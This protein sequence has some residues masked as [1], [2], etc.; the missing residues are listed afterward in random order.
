MDGRP[1]ILAIETA[2]PC[3]SVALCRGGLSD[4]ALVAEIGGRPDKT[5]SRRLLVQ[6]KFLL[7]QSELSWTD[8]DGVAVSLGPG[9]FT[10]L[11]IGMA[12][13]RGI[14]MAAG[15]PLLGVPT[16][17]GIALANGQC[18]GPLHVIL[19][20]RKRQ[21]FA[22]SYQAHGQGMPV[23]QGEVLAIAPD[24]LAARLHA[25]ATLVGDGV[26]LYA[27]VFSAIH[28][29][30]L[31]SPVQGTPRALHIGL[32]GAEALRRGELL[33]DTA[34]PFYVRRSEAEINAS[35]QP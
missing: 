6:V 2:T 4:G 16:V 3:G 30:R 27:E 26:A 28:G 19:D 14:A 35:K 5:H 21:V 25:P 15:R 34:P 29:A 33:S 18:E 22:A 11:R 9:S 10:G 8:L 12:A 1:L 13:A 7:D 20:A 24:Q 32:L 31:L 23:R 17:D